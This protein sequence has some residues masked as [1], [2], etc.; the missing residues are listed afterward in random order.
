MNTCISCLAYNRMSLKE[1]HVIPPRVGTKHIW[2]PTW[3]S[4]SD[5]PQDYCD[6]H[7]EVFDP[8]KNKHASNGLFLYGQEADQA[9]KQ[10]KTFIQSNDERY[11]NAAQMIANGQILVE[12]KM[13]EICSGHTLAIIDGDLWLQTHHLIVNLGRYDEVKDTYQSLIDLADTN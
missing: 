1:K 4:S 3:I 7:A 13:R 10:T 6:E 5:G 12:G 2:C 8:T 9:F 11:Q